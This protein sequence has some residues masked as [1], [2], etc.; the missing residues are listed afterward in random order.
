M[1]RTNPAP[2]A[3]RGPNGLAILGR[4]PHDLR[5]IRYGEGEGGAAPAAAETP[6]AGA[7]APVPAPPTTQTTVTTSPTWDGKVESLDPAVQKMITD[8]RTE[9][10]NH[11]VAAKTAGEKAQTD[12]L[13]AFAKAAGLELPGDKPDPDKLA[14]DL[15]AS[16][17]AAR[18]S[19]IKLAVYQAAG[20][21]QGNPDALLD[22]NTFLAKVDTLDPTAADFGTQV[23]EAIKAAVTANPSLKQTRAVGAST[24]DTPGGTGE[25]GQITEEQLAQMTPQEINEA[26]EKG[27]LKNLL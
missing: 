11:R 3:L 22:S 12:L 8:L 20:A 23:G 15:A 26:L 4:T 19:T 7:T 16:N 24:V 14:A 25:Q 18:E 6:P 27:L 9:A 2:C 5:G 10:G 1:F 17:K 13:T 21:H